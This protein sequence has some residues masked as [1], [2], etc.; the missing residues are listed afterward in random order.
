MRILLTGV[1]G[2]IGSQVAR[3]LL[4]EGHWVYGLDNLNTYY[5]PA[6]KRHRLS[7]LESF[8]NFRFFPGDLAD[9]TTMEA[10]FAAVAPLDA[11]MN[12]A[13]RAGVRAS[14]TDPLVYHHT[15]ATGSLHLL[16]LM[17]RYEVPR[18][19]LAST[20]S[21]Y[22]GS[23]LP[24]TED[25]PVNTPISPY[26][27]SKKAAEVMAYTYH[28]HYGLHVA[29]L[30]YFTVYGPAG[31][32]DMSIFRFIEWI[33]RGQPVQLYGDGQQ[34]RDFTYVE[35]VARA[36][37]AALQLSGYHILNVGG[38]R[39]PTSLLSVI[40]FMEERLGKKAQ[41]E[42]KPFPRADILHTQADIS[43]TTALLGWKPEVDF[44]EGL[45]RTLDW[46]LAHRDLLDTLPLP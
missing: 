38:G 15:N 1:A 34:S 23:D 8:P 43:R 22:A 28:Y 29:I 5:S 27:A 11:V 45:Q 40:A 17:R 12:L 20:S 42:Y 19:V 21:L 7:A 2:F 33:Y 44:W 36:T 31:R 26:A 16:E 32:P 24:F 37:V 46:H 10:L 39:S 18:Y 3:R 30:R 25:R 14:L 41:I 9:W 6:L 35:D 13:A 4:E